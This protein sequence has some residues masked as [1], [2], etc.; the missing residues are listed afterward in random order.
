VHIWCWTKEQKYVGWS[1]QTAQVVL[2]LKTIRLQGQ[3]TSAVNSQRGI[4]I[5]QRMLDADALLRQ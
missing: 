1:I 2:M 5:Q 3:Q 4:F